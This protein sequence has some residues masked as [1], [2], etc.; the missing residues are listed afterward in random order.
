MEGKKC[1]RN[2]YYKRKDKEER[3]ALGDEERE[4]ETVAE[5]VAAAQS[6]YRSSGMETV[7]HSDHKETQTWKLRSNSVGPCHVSLRPQERY[8]VQRGTTSSLKSQT[9]CL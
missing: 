2:S 8:A 5:T 1:E 6:N 4:T 7:G 9:C 3:Q